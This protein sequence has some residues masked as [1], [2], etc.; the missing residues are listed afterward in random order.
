MA[1]YTL[2]GHSVSL[3]LHA[4]KCCVIKAPCMLC[5]MQMG[6]EW[7]AGRSCTGAATHAPLSEATWCRHTTTA[8]LP[9]GP[10]V[11]DVLMP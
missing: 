6:L 10:H 1:G 4:Y 5:A 3:T 2:L 7:V 9:C 8:P 11:R